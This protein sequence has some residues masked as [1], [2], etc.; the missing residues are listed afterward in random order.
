[1]GLGAAVAVVVVFVAL[2]PGFSASPKPFF[3]GSKPAYESVE[4]LGGKADLVVV[5]VVGDVVARQAEETTDLPFV[6]ISF[7][8]DQVLG[9]SLAAQNT[10]SVIVS[11]LDTDKL[12]V[13]G[14]TPLVSGQ[15]VLLFLEKISATDAPPGVIPFDEVFVP[16]SDDNGVF[17]VAADGSVTA[18]SDV[19]VS[20]TSEGV[21]DARES[22]P[23]PE[24]GKN[25]QETPVRIVASFRMEEI[26]RE[27]GL[28]SV[29]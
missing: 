22:R 24:V 14:L 25:G 29:E 16:L 19:V 12:T 26:Q 23:V 18:R 20:V 10:D 28:A 2:W 3:H 17:D 11:I 15:R 27:L 5:G 6:Y 13:D 1:M 21:Q 4:D 8:V 7:S 9:N